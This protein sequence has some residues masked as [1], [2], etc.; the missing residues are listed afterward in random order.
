MADEKQIIG[1][2]EWIQL[3]GLDGAIVKAKVD[4]GARTSSL[5]AFDVTEIERDGEIWIE[6]GFHPLQRDTTITARGSARLVDRRMITASSGH[7]EMRYVVE[8][9]LELNG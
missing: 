9:D 1:W 8:T 3:P 2:R 7:S 5:H 4:T 6:F